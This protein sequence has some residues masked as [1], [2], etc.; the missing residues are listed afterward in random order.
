MKA[1]FHDSVKKYKIPGKILTED[2]KVLYTEDNKT[3]EKEGKN[4]PCLQL[5]K[6]I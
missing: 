5:V 3:L 2:V 6:I 1:I 4:L